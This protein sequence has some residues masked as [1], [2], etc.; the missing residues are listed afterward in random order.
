MAQT[1][2]RLWY[3]QPAK[4]FEEAIVLGNGKL[5]ATVFG[6]TRQEKIYLN[7]ATLWSGEPVNAAMNPEA[8]KHV[9][10][11]R[12]ALFEE[13]YPLAD[14]LNKRLQGKFSES[15]APLGTLL[16]DFPLEQEPLQ[17]TRVLDLETALAH[18]TF[19]VGPNRF[20]REYLISYPDRIFAIRLSSDHQG[21]LNFSL[22]FVSELR[23][24]TSIA[25]GRLVANGYA[26]I[27]AEPS[28]R[29]DIKDAIVFDPARGTRFTTSIAIQHQGGQLQTTDSTLLLMGARE[30]V[31]Y[32]SVATSFNGFDKNPATEGLDNQKIA[33]DQLT[34]ALLKGYDRILNDHLADYQPLFNRVHLSFGKSDAPEIPTDQRLQRYGTGKEDRNL[35]ILYFNF[36][37]YLLIASSRTPGVPANLQGIW[38]PYMR[39][40]WS[41]NYTTN[42]NLE[43]NYWPAE[44]T[45]LSEMHL[46]LLGFIGNVAK[47]G[48]ITARTFYGVDGWSLAHNSD[49]WAM[50]N[51]V[52]DFGKGDPSWANWNMG[53]AWMATHL[54]EHYTFTMDEQYLRSTAWPLMKGAAT[55]C[56]QWLTSDKLGNLVTAPSTSPENIYVTNSG[57]KGAT[58]YGSTADM[59]MIRELFLQILEAHKVLK[60]D[61]AFCHEIEAALKRLYPYQ[62]GQRGQLQE[63]YHDWNDNEPLH[64][65]QSH[66]FG[67]HPGHH[68]TPSATPALADA[69]RKTLEIKGDETTGWSKGW[70]ISLWARLWDGNHAYKMFRE[71]LRFVEPD[72]VRPKY[73]QGGGTYPNLFDAHPPFQ[74]DG[75]FGGTAA[76]AEMLVQS[77]LESIRL[78]P[79]LPDAWREGSVSGLKARGGY[80]VSISWSDGKLKQVTL[81]NPRDATTEIQYDGK[82]RKVSARAGQ[83]VTIKW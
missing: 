2:T 24:Q 70:R 23:F 44:T 47:T 64:R 28:Y 77:D 7:D 82:S 72:G 60:T 75:N 27:H 29:G 71:L 33:S 5:G 8:H 12:K 4:H 63:W 32:V 74:I 46:P 39:P 80:T 15:F 73:S 68:I 34:A 83:S 41:S 67:L 54:W 55:F 45:N 20:K 56:L 37:R 57:Y 21:P 51:P 48:S 59:A 14:S 11:I 43:E 9:P 26:P 50:S 81:L 36:G 38:N 13:N 18:T 10:A 6:G 62:I 30:A 25:G 31:I 22:R 66:L 53:G 61:S 78:L 79:A 65:H 3:Q 69:C 58:L 40:P 17:Y 42:I 16:I 49:I 76:I 35:E 52:G 19:N 1:A